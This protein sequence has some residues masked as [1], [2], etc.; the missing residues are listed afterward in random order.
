MAGLHGFLNVLLCG[1][2][3]FTIAAKLAKHQREESGR[4]T[5]MQNFAT[6]NTAPPQLVK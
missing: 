2:N 4:R 6:L 3:D 5:F 1:E